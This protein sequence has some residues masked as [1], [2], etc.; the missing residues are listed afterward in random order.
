[1]ARR[2]QAKNRRTAEMRGRPGPS[3]RKV[4]GTGGYGG[5][6]QGQEGT[7]LVEPRPGHENQP[8]HNE[9]KVGAPTAQQPARGRHGT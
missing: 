3:T 9:T 1:M 4:T 8:A 6:P 5:E 2:R 7:Q